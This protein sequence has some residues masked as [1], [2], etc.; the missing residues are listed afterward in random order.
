M[1]GSF[2]TE[3]AD[4]ASASRPPPGPAGFPRVATCLPARDLTAVR[5]VR[6][7]A[8]ATLRY[9][10]VTDRSDDITLVLSELVTN[11]LQHAAPRTGGW[12][13]RVGLVQSRPAAAVLCAVADASPAPP[14]PRPPG[15]LAESGRGVHV[16]EE[17]SDDWGYAIAPRRG[18]VV[19]ATFAPPAGPTGVSRPPRA[20]ARPA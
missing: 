10:E 19:W 16:I 9:W 13:V 1:S 6:D 7:F 8:R 5:A 2:L 18:K 15:H 17:L 11:A 3:A 20:A 4:D 14:V 12:P